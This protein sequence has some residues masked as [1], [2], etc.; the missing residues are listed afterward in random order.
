MWHAALL[1]PIPFDVPTKISWDFM[2]QS[3]SNCTM[4]DTEKV[5][6]LIVGAGW[7]RELIATQVPTG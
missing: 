6:L 2:R 7:S 4:C 3:C 5:D 1:A